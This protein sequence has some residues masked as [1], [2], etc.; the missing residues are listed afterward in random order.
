MYARTRGEEEKE[1]EEDV[2]ECT[3]SGGNARDATRS[4]QKNGTISDEIASLIFN[5]G[6]NRETMSG[7]KYNF[8]KE[9]LRLR[10]RFIFVLEFELYI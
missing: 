10:I 2:I 4:R 5:L 6:R 9:M 7:R 8:A 1:E 3:N